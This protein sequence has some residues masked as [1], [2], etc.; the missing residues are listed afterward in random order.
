VFDLGIILLYHIKELVRDFLL[1][2]L[3]VSTLSFTQRVCVCSYSLGLVLYY[4]YYFLR[5]GL[6]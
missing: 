1:F 6:I 5:V 4:I 3:L 2:I